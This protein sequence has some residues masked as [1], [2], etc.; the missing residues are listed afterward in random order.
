MKTSIPYAVALGLLSLL[1]SRFV[2]ASVAS[3]QTDSVHFCQIIDPDEWERERALLPAAK[4][5]VLSAGHSRIVRL[6]YFLPEDRTYRPAVVAAMKTGM[7]EVQTFYRDQMAAHGFGNK[8]FQI[9]TDAQ[10]VPIVHRVNGNHSDDYYKTRGRPEDEIN[11]AFD[12]SSIVQLIVMD[13]SRSSGGTGVGIKQRGMGIVYGGWSW[14]TAAHELGH[15]FGLQHDF[16]GDSYIMSY[17]ANPNALSACAA[18]FLAVSPYFNPSVSFSAGSP[19]GFEL[20][21]SPDYTHGKTSV[22]VRFR[23]RD[24]D[25]LHEMILFVKTPEG[26]GPF[27]PAGF[28]EV[29]ACRELDGQTDITVQFDY[30]GNT[31][32]DEGS[33]LLLPL[34]HTVYV[35]TVD[36][37]G[38]RVDSPIPVTLRATNIRQA[39]VPVGERSP[40]VRESIYNV[41]RTFYDRTVSSYEE[42]TDAHLANITN[43]NVLDIHASDS[44]LQSNDFD[45]LTN[46]D[47]LELR[48][49]F[50]SGFSE[51]SLLPA[52]IFNGLTSLR[53]F[54][55]RYYTHI[56]G[57]GTQVVPHLPF[58]VGLKKVGAAQFKAVVHTGAPF[59]MVLPLHLVNGRISSGA[60]TISIPAG[61]VESAPVSVTRTPG[62][63]AAVIVDIDTLPG[64]PESHYFS[65]YGS[66][67]KVHPNYTFYRSSLPL[68]IFSPL[69]GAPAPVAQR[70]S[71]VLDAI[72]AAVPEINHIH[73]D[74]ELRYIIDGRF[75]DKKN[76]MGNYVSEA[77]LAAITRLDVSGGGNL[78]LGGNW[79]GRHGDVTVLK[80]GDFDG[81]TSLTELRL[82]DNRISALSSGVFDQLTNLTELKLD[83]NNLNSLPSGMF[84]QLAKLTELF[85]SDN[86]LNT[87]PSGVFDELTKLTILAINN[88]KLSS[89]PSGVFDEL[90]KLTILA[91]NNN[92]LSSLPSGVF[93]QLTSLTR[94]YLNSNK[95]SSLPSGVFDQ[96]TSL[97][98]L[99]LFDNPLS[100]LRESDFD[101]LSNLE[102][103]ILPGGS[104]SNP[105]PEFSG[106]TRVID[107]T[108]QVRDAILAAAG[109]ESASD[110]TD[111]HL[112]AI[113]QLDL[114]GQNIT[115]LKVGDF[116]NL[117]GL[118][119][120]DLAD[121]RLSSL[122]ADIFEFLINL[123]VIGLSDNQLNS[124][125]EG[126]FDNL[127]SVKM[128]FL[129]GNQLSSLAEGLFD[130][131]AN[132]LLIDLSGNRLSSLPMGLF[133]RVTLG[134][135][136]GKNELRSLPAGLFMGIFAERPDFTGFSLFG[137]AL[138]PLPVDIYDELPNPTILDL[139]DNPGAPLSIV[140]SLERVDHGRF[141]II[142]PTGVPF[143]I[144]LPLTLANG[145]ISGGA[146]TLSM[147]TGSVESDTL[148]V[149]RTHGTTFAVTV[150]I[151][152]LPGLPAKHRGYNLVK[153][154]DL[155]LI[156]SEFGGRISVCERTP[157]VRDAIVAMAP[158]SA[159][160]AVTEGHLAAITSLS[161]YERGIW[162]LK[163]GDFSGLTNLK[164]LN[165]YGNQLSSLP[166]DLFDNL[167]NLTSLDLRRNQ[168][169][170]L[171]AGLFDNLTDLEFLYLAVN[172]LRLLPTGLFDKLTNLE[173]LYLGAN[174]L[175]S[176]PT[177]LL[178]N[179]AKL[180][181][182]D[183]RQNEL[184]SLP[185]GIFD[186]LTNPHLA[187]Q[188]N[189]NR[190]NTLP[191]ALFDNLTLSVDLSRNQLSSLPVGLF[192]NLTGLAYL[193]LD[194]NLV[195]PLLLN[196]SLQH[197]P[198][199]DQFKAV[200]PTAAPFELVLP[201]GVSGPGAIAGRATTVTIP[202]GGRESAPLAI[203]RTPGTTGG[204]NVDIG[205][206][207]E[208]PRHHTGYALVKFGDLPLAY[209][210]AA[211]GRRGTPEAAT[212]FNGDG[213]TDFIDFF[214][215]ADAYGSTNAKFDLDGNGTVDFADFFK[216]VDA[217][218][219]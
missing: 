192:D 36:T 86:Q 147:S 126:L 194:D 102:V 84:D 171:S 52:R 158:V 39:S 60:T 139:R 177:G 11:R 62:T 218:G 90:T 104:T 122:P 193:N 166:A 22:P 120:L 70:T 196:V 110:V 28:M 33:S 21:S 54:R 137:N 208:L 29:K 59:D 204:I 1:L 47:R 165:I 9:E 202:A 49:D 214:L 157:R 6:F 219:S 18:R 205:T 77:H 14:S 190:L 152:D 114:S 3:S 175:R 210:L 145:S 107:R 163:R 51:E 105:L 169:G 188:L 27:S 85:L 173:G 35:S 155:P 185:T 97:T 181:E 201:V 144:A 71:Q 130:G 197:G 89:L 8:T 140:V 88:N 111:A 57:E 217:F 31:P 186:N 138:G 2:V 198:G 64:P 216:F 10:G 116:D 146:T 38:N 93:D 96:L 68:E 184:T 142:A 108:S 199:G 65:Y 143:D 37:D 109:V 209:Y 101:H 112:A 128:I 66:E 17:G 211:E 127:T 182:L 125:P 98:L 53:S 95:L 43:M 23:A 212:D 58:P 148:T 141:K 4:T 74:W 40:R 46:L 118:V 20:T 162:T 160:G 41:V 129:D 56:H 32:S 13:I 16:R 82:D 61:Y 161:L 91:I 50:D 153:S 183:L 55:I 191:H 30:D 215:F 156:F 7:L 133:H 176:L 123:K 24:P 67:T 121:N 164:S 170:S 180:V 187:I 63:T 72:L 124:L 189:R 106:D 26:L 69:S 200:T 5:T 150:N 151:G 178:D 92:K 45:G 80:S 34:E 48:L 73:H 12:T 149:T 78:D 117:T 79:F 100:S 115:E 76:N 206:M 113:K 83:G 207:P 119:G 213:K 135:L 42:V 136:L 134:L 44:P 99:N 19:P 203:V 154:A 81:L 103:L 15:A 159:C 168:L 179:L 167:T 94:L 172:Q 131:P 25:G 174:Q 195:D 75:I 132:L 87:L